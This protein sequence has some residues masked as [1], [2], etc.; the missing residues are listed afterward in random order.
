MALVRSFACFIEL[1][2]IKI[3]TWTIL[4]GTSNKG[5]VQ[6]QF[7]IVDEIRPLHIHS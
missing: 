1:C 3:G 6:V 5:F 7:L 2:K 4:V